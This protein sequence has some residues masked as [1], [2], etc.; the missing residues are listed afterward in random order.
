MSNLRKP[1][2]LIA[3]MSLA[4]LTAW[5]AFESGDPRRP[6]IKPAPKAV[7]YQDSV[8]IWTICDGR[9]KGVTKGMR[10]TLGQCE[11][12]LKE[13]TGDAGRVIAKW[14]KTPITQDQY[15][16]LALFVGNLGP[17]KPD[18]KD[19]FVWLK[20]RDKHG[21][22]RHSTMLKQINAGNC[23]AVVAEFPKWASAGGVPLPGLEVRRKYEAGLFAKGCPWS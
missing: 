11:A 10:A 7:A 13:D 18:V 2:M 5:S 6:D 17:G 14:V 9:T 23:E 20:K 12:W 1:A 22:P 15:D 4:G 21:N 8:G 16:A 3:A 19:G